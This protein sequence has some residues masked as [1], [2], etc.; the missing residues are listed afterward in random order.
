MKAIEKDRRRRYES[1]TDMARDLERYLD[2]QPVVAR[3]PSQMYRL[4]KFA[5]RNKVAFVTS[6][7]VTLALVAGTMVSTWQ[8]VRATRAFDEAERLRK[9]AVE[10]ADRLKEANVLLDNARANADEKRWSIAWAQYTRAAW[11]QPDHYPAWS[12][13][14][15]LGV[16]LGAWTTAAGDFAA[17][18]S[19]GAPA[20][21]PGWWGV[22]PLFLFTGDEDSYQRVCATLSA[23]LDASDDVMFVTYAARSLLVQPLP[24]ED[25]SRLVERMEGLSERYRVLLAP[26]AAT[27]GG[28]PFG[29]PAA[30]SQDPH[31]P[32]RDPDRRPKEPAPGRFLPGPGMPFGNGIP[33]VINWYVTGLAHYRS[34]NAEQAL[35]HLQRVI[36]ADQKF[37]PSKLALPVLAMARHEL[38]QSEE[39]LADLSEAG[40]T[41]DRWIADAAKGSSE[42]FSLPWFDLVESL[43]LYR[44]AH[45]LIRGTPPPEDDRLSRMEQ[46]ALA[47]L[48]GE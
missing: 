16:R 5:Q 41:I 31:P 29:I 43:V 24:R 8:A 3:P 45:R 17:A 11:L 1:A 30:P 13:R 23:Q 4:R 14:G 19:L 27:G 22:P 40:A 39:A 35:V 32:E 2:H 15:S 37:P 26:F 38:G 46:S 21:N 10:F 18:L 9:D 33:Q 28:G 48:R 42:P 47:R 34:A 36:A 6:T 25:A 7:L 44:E 12:G 20:N